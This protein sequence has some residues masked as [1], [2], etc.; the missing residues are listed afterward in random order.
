MRE[1]QGDAGRDDRAAD[2]CARHHGAAAI[3]AEAEDVLAVGQQVRLNYA[4]TIKQRPGRYA[5]AAKA[6]YTRLRFIEA[7]DPDHVDEVSRIVQCAL[8]RTLVTDRG[9]DNDAFGGELIDLGDKRL[10]HEIVATVRKIDDIDVEFEHLVK[11]VEEPLS[12]GLVII[13][14]GFENVDFGVWREAWATLVLGGD[15]GCDEGA[16]ADLVGWA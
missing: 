1:S 13:A 4:K 7:A 11:G 10:V 9:N 15:D 3:D 14:E 6:G 5:A 16:V 12:V 8:E 2:R